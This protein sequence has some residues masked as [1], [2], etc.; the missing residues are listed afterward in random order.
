M[1]VFFFAP[2]SILICCQVVILVIGIDISN[3]HEPDLLEMACDVAEELLVSLA[4]FPMFRMPSFQHAI[5]SFSRLSSCLRCQWL[6]LLGYAVAYWACVGQSSKT[7]LAHLCQWFQ[8]R[9]FSIIWVL[10]SNMFFEC[11]FLGEP[12]FFS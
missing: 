12:L 10:V 2:G 9:L 5:N 1:L 7:D 3:R 4:F 11:A 8:L 6:K